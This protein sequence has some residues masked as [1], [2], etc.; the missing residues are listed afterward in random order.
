LNISTK[1]MCKSLNPLTL[2]VATRVNLAKKLQ[3][4]AS[5]IYTTY[6]L[7]GSANAEYRGSGKKSFI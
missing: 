5:K 1:I 7:C 4:H 6:P 2:V 3:V